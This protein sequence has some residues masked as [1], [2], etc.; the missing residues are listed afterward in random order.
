MPWIV[1]LDQ[2]GAGPESGLEA[3]NR[4]QAESLAERMRAA[5]VRNG[6]PETAVIIRELDDQTRERRRGD[7][8]KGP[9]RRNESPPTD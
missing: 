5:A 3:I 7:R 8:R 6:L 9:R 4:D 2:D 1:Y